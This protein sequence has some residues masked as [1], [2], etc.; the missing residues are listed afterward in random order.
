MKNLRSCSLSV[1]CPVSIVG[2]LRAG[3]SETDEKT[4]HIAE[5]TLSTI[6][7]LIGNLLSGEVS[8]ATYHPQLVIQTLDMLREGTPWEIRRRIAE[9]LPALFAAAPQ[10]LPTVLRLLQP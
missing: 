6:D 1:G 2:E 3:W 8:A 7:H 9:A 10:S 4:Q 5:D